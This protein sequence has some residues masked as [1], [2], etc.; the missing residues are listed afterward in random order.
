MAAVTGRLLADISLTTV[1]VGK[2]LFH[3]EPIMLAPGQGEALERVLEA[4][5]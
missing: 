2:L 4:V 5:R 1:A 3:F